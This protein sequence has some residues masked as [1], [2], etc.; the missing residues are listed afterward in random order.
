MKINLLILIVVI[1]YNFLGA[2]S[3]TENDSLYITA[4]EKYTIEIDSFYT[5]YNV[6]NIKYDTL[7]INKNGVVDN[8]PSRIH[9][10]CVIILSDTNKIEI[11][12]RNKNEIVEVKLFPIEIKSGQIEIT[13][14]PYQCKFNKKDEL[15]IE[16]NY[17]ISAWTNVFFK[18]DCNKRKWKYDRTK[19]GG[20]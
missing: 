2:Q 18:Y 19:N 5:K 7:Y 15:N 1:S 17:L 16:Y 10:R 3:F 6:N 12:E 9:G 8:L 14:V 13:I 4:L 11:Y 20:V